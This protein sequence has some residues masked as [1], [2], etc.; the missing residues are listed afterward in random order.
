MITCQRVLAGR[1]YEAV[2]KH[3]APSRA[4]RFVFQASSCRGFG[5]EKEFGEPE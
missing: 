2:K 4:W 5:K 1:N 3:P